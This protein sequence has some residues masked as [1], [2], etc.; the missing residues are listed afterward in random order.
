MTLRER[1][2]AGLPLEGGLVVD[3]HGHLGR[4]GVFD[5]PAS[6]AAEAVAVMDRVGVDVLCVSHVLSLVG[7]WV[8]G[9]DLVAQAMQEFPGRFVGYAVVNP[10]HPGTVRAELDRCVERLGM[11]GIKVHA[12]LHEYPLDGPAMMAVYEYAAEKGGLPVL[13]HGFND[14][15]AM[16]KLS[17]VFPTVPFIVA[18]SGGGYRGRP[19][20]IIDLVADRDN[21][22]TDVCSSLVPYGGIEA[23][24]ERVGAGKVLFGSDFT[25][26]HLTHQIGR[27][28]LAD[29]T[30]QDKWAIIGGNA[31]RLF[32]LST[33]GGG[34]E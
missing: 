22:Y 27:V 25:W 28:L 7:D 13:G 34:H 14:A 15:R 29:L 12:G 32:G 4:Y 18:H 1:A 26:Q 3:A 24:V 9:N 33:R 6:T 31:A 8:R 23:L 17:A 11:K 10:N 21:L 16:E 5:M 20:A 19:E 2:L 30:E